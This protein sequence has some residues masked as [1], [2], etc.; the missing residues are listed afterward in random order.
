M[1][2]K[3]SVRRFPVTN[4]GRFSLGQAPPPVNRL[5]DIRTDF[6]LSRYDILTGGEKGWQVHSEGLG[7]SDIPAEVQRTLYE[8]MQNP[9]EEELRD[10]AL[11]SSFF[12]MP[13]Y[14]ENL[15]EACQY[16]Q[17]GQVP[18]RG[19]VP[20]GGWKPG[21]VQRFG[22]EDR[23]IDL[24]SPFFCPSLES[25][26]DPASMRYVFPAFGG[27]PAYF[28]INFTEY[29]GDIRYAMNN[30]LTFMRVME[31]Y[32]FPSPIGVRPQVWYY[33][34]QKEIQDLLRQPMYLP[35]DLI[36]FWVTMNL[37]LNYTVVA[38]EVLRQL[39]SKAKR[40]KRK[41][42]IEKIAMAA[43][44]AIITAGIASAI[45]PLIPAGAVITSSQVAGSITGGL[46]QIVSIQEKKQAAKSM[47]KIAKQFEQDDPAW[48]KEVDEAA[49][50]LDRDA[51]EEEKYATMTPEEREAMDEA[52]QE[53]IPTPATAG[54]QYDAPMPGV[55]V[56]PI[57]G[58]VAAAGLLAWA[59][60][61]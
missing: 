17:T 40:Q 41:A 2:I 59:L 48:A 27:G 54:Y 47:E 11:M 50:F 58:G 52:A 51:A 43:A 46:N 31:S 25:L 4:L 56:L 9:S 3:N 30:A 37:A 28:G 55:N 44:L 34:S 60:L 26:P 42:L 5:M 21:S 13:N 10:I 22:V 57:V 23:S 35:A 33:H 61:S 45:A 12:D 49:H 15:Y 19:P 36:R 39:E 38:N 29:W 8:V 1:F 6:I 53:P 7:I 32:P 14:S 24:A 20:K 16:V 18:Q